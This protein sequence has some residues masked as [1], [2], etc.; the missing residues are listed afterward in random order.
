MGPSPWGTWGPYLRIPSIEYFPNVFFWTSWAP[1]ASP[2]LQMLWDPAKNLIIFQ[3]AV[4]SLLWLKKGFTC[5]K[6]KPKFELTHSCG[7]SFLWYIHRLKIAHTCQSR[8]E[9]R[10]TGRS[11]SQGRRSGPSTLFQASLPSAKTRSI[12][13]KI[14][15]QNHPRSWTSNRGPSRSLLLLLNYFHEQFDK[16]VG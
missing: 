13:E 2:Y 4:I 6:G 16:Y 12:S 15:L 5:S 3:G 11:S 7:D 1:W 14:H 9:S 8:R 10:R